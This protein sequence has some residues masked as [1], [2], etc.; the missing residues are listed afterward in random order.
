MDFGSSPVYLVDVNCYKPPEEL[1]INYEKV[2]EIW[3][4]QERYPREMWGFIQKI[5]DRAGLSNTETHLPK[6]IHPEYSA[7]KEDTSMDASM[8][9]AK[10]C[11]FGAVSGLLEKTGLKPTDIDI[12]VTSCSIFCPTPSMSAM[13]VNHFG[14]KSSIQSYHLGGMGCSMGVVGVNLIRDLLKAH[15]NSN[16]LFVC[17]E[18]TTPAY[19]PGTERSRIVTNMIFR[20]G[21][22]AI[23]FSNRRSMKQKAKYELHACI[24]VHQGCRDEAFGCIQYAPDDEGINGIYLGKNVVTEAS[25]G[26]ESTLTQVAPYVLDAGQIVQYLW[27]ELRRKFDPKTPKFVPSFEKCLDHVLIH[28]GGAKI[29]EGIGK[30]LNLS[31]YMLAPSY[32]VLHYYGNVSSSSTWYTLS[33]VESLRGVKKGHLVLQV[34]VGSGVK[35]GVN[36]WKATKNVHEVHGAWKHVWDKRGQV[37]DERTSSKKKIIAGSFSPRLIVQFLMVIVF[38]LMAVYLSEQHQM[39]DFMA[40]LIPSMKST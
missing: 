34:G 14:M 32:D 17:T 27:L 18:T 38:M 35:C 12:L 22:S 21:G 31:E 39:K 7:G 23:L 36:V 40:M 8:A 37:L 25:K 9:E 24:R 19:Y 30:S 16:A 20:M 11:L 3:R 5:K 28:A 10:M 13:I 26:L 15:P 6:N 4:E 29:L 1:R 2:E 33:N